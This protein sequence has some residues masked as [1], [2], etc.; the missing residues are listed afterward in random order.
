[1]AQNDATPGDLGGSTPLDEPLEDFLD[2]K[3]KTISM[4]GEEKQRSGTYARELERLLP[5][6]VAWMNDQG[7]HSF[8]QLDGRA[9]ATYAREELAHRVKR[10]ELSTRTAWKYL[11]YISAYLNYCQEWEYT[12]D[13]PV[14]TGVVKDSM[15]EKPSPD[16]SDQQFWSV[17]QLQTLMAHVDERAYEA[18]EEHGNGRDA[19]VPV[20][21]RAF[22][23][24]IGYSGV[25]GAE[26]LS[27]P[28]DDRADRSGAT[29]EDI[30]FEQRRLRVLGKSQDYEDVPTTSYPIEPFKRWHSLLDPPQDDWPL[31]PSLH[32]PTLWREARSQLV[33]RNHDEET[34]DSLL[35]PITEPLDAYYKHNLRPP[36][37]STTGGRH[38]LK[39][40]TDAAGVDTSSDSK[41]YLTLHGG[42]RGV[43]EQYRRQEGLS[44]A[45]KALR[46][47]D[48]STTENMYSHIEA[49]EISKIGDGVFDEQSQ[50]VNAETHDQEDTDASQ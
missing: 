17:E 36:G 2:D 9:I 28:H 42:R 12:P 11:D 40:L 24:L 27:Q 41:D 39:R 43:G 18:I 44:S 46:H 26:V 49:T 25:R 50:G 5:E 34:I 23:A 1:M 32:T 3:A 45:Q 20:R 31:F 13:N 14:R 29:W 15:P 6:W 35:D 10:D 30:E 8:E 4:D 7:Y 19:F 37:M 33:A 16:S 48:P 47:S 21:D 38:L 22:C